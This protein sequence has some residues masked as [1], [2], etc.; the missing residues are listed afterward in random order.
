MP[1]G[2]HT[3]R[4]RGAGVRYV[5]FSFMSHCG[6]ESVVGTTMTRTTNRY[7]GPTRGLLTAVEDHSMMTWGLDSTTFF[8]FGKPIESLPS[9]QVGTFLPY[10]LSLS[11][12]CMAT[13]DTGELKSH[14]MLYLCMHVC[15]QHG[16]RTEKELKSQLAIRYL[17]IEH[18]NPEMGG[19]GG[20]PTLFEG[21]LVVQ[22]STVLFKERKK[23]R[24]S[25]TTTT[26]SIVN[27][28]TLNSPLSHTQKKDRNLLL[29]QAL[30][31]HFQL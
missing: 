10:G 31:A 28:S 11:Q 26:D 15:M 1:V 14:E 19:G 6:K 21:C 18:K 17:G 24:S 2:A 7:E 4:S 13:S 8:C 9:I 23:L 29:R 22:Y 3:R 20:K 27:P 5:L 30:S 16:Q 25:T 12:V